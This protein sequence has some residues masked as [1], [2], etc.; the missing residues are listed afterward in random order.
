MMCADAAVK[1]HEICQLVQA[2]TVADKGRELLGVLE[3]GCGLLRV[4]AS[5]VLL[6]VS[7]LLEV[8]EPSSGLVRTSKRGRLLRV[9]GGGSPVLGVHKG[10]QV[11]Y[12]G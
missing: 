5:G 11:W 8:L 3:G 6:R 12:L 1:L 2:A 10:G 9:S 4:L 7:G